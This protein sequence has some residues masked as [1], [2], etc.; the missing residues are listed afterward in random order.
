VCEKIE[1]AAKLSPVMAVLDT[2][3][4]EKAKHFTLNPAIGG[5]LNRHGVVPAEAGTQ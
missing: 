3:I 2:A 1:I 4:H 5:T